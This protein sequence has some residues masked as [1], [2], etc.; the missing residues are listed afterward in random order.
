MKNLCLIYVSM[1]KSR[2]RQLISMVI[3]K[4]TLGNSGFDHGDLGWSAWGRS[5]R[6]ARTRA[7]VRGSG[8][9][10]GVIHT[11]NSCVHVTH[12]S[13]SGRSLSPAGMKMIV[14]GVSPSDLGWMIVPQRSQVIVRAMI[15]SV[16]SMCLCAMC[17][18]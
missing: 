7:R 9:D 8:F 18:R 3:R 5:A 10:L 4:V 2:R 12:K 11:R 16:P 17:A 15:V 1:V 13:Y 14:V 6:V